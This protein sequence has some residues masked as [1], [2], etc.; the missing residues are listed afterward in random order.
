[1][2][3]AKEYLMYIL[4]SLP[5]QIVSAIFGMIISFKFLRPGALFKVKYRP[6]KSNEWFIS[7]LSLLIRVSFGVGVK[8]ALKALYD[9][10]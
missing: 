3:K 5:G 4:G 7:L 8:V 10:N 1:M 2:G 6:I 9:K